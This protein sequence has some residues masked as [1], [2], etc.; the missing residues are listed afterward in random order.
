[1]IDL[2]SQLQAMRPKK[3]GD[4]RFRVMLAITSLYHSLPGLAS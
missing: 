2:E 3:F 1:M 4:S